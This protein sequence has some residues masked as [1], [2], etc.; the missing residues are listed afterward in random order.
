[1]SR[2][3]GRLK[4]TIRIGSKPPAGGKTRISTAKIEINMMPSRK[5]GT[6]ERSMNGGNAARMK[7]GV[8]GQAPSAPSSV[9]RLKSINVDMPSSPS[10]HGSAL[11]TFRSERRQRSAYEARRARPG[12][13]CAQ[14]RA[15]AEV[16]QRRHAQQPERPRQRTANFQIGTA[17][18]QRV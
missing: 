1:M 11:R 2:M 8:R 7:R 17:A 4:R 16:D 14:Q 15:Q 12:T 5:N 6:A 10:V 9:P 18:T 13:K 3:V